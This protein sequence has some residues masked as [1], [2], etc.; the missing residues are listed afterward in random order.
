MPSTT[1]VKSIRERQC[2]VLPSLW[3]NHSSSGVGRNLH[4]EVK[5][6]SVCGD[7]VFVRFEVPVHSD[8]AIWTNIPGVG[9]G[10]V[11]ARDR[12]NPDPFP[13]WFCWFQTANIRVHPAS[14]SA[15]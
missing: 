3:N 13:A 2:A 4:L 15:E 14:D 7:I 1:D 8:L 11:A 9:E 6:V 10:Y 5:A 12:R